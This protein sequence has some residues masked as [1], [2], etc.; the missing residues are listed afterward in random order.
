[1]A[2]AFLLVGNQRV[3]IDKAQVEAPAIA[4]APSSAGVLKEVYVS[5]GDVIAPNS[6]VAEVGTE[7]IKSVSGGL[8]IATDNDIGAQVTSATAVVTMIDPNELRVVGEL[9]EGKGLADIHVGDSAYFTVDA[10]GGKRFSGVVDEVSP[11]ARTGDVVFSISD[12]RATQS[13]DVKIAFD[14]ST[15]PQLKNG[16]SARIWVYKQ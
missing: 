5:P 16:M 1:M 15:Y 10:F 14:P 12:K 2:L 11:T 7:L 3:Y 9:D 4:L 8:V 6:V 13:F